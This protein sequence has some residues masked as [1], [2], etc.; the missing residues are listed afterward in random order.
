MKVLRTAA[1]TLLLCLPA[2]AGAQRFNF[3]QQP[4]PGAVEVKWNA[5]SGAPLFD[6]A[7]GYGFVERTG[8]LPARPVHTATIRSDGKG[9]TISE[10]AFDADANDNAVPGYARLLQPQSRGRISL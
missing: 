3:T 6:A 1:V 2:L 5:R 4:S 9:F 7:T 8:A 10:P